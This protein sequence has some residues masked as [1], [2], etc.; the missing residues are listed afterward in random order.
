VHSISSTELTLDY[1][2]LTPVTSPTGGTYL[3][4]LDRVGARYEILS[5]SGSTG[6]TV[7]KQLANGSPDTAWSG[8]FVPKKRV[9]PCHIN[10]ESR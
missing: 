8:F 10:Y 3:A 5:L 7:E 1:P 2:D 6:I 4:T 9:P